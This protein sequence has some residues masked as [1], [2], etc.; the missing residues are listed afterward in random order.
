MLNKESPNLSKNFYKH[1]F[2]LI[3][4]VQKQYQQMKKTLLRMAVW[5]LFLCLYN[6]RRRH[7]KCYMTS[8]SRLRKQEKAKW[9]WPAGEVRGDLQD[10]IESKMEIHTSFTLVGTEQLTFN[11]YRKYSCLVGNRRNLWS[12]CS[13]TCGYAFEKLL[14]HFKGILS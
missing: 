14:W 8:I 5:Q 13:G 12:L 9:R 7:K 3:T 1:L 4:E 2:E 11:I 6:Q 10:W